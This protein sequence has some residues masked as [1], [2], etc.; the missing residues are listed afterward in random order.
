VVLAAAVALGFAA[1]VV[2]AFVFGVE[3][4]LALGDALAVAFEFLLFRRD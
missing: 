3:A 2:T 1:G 4:T